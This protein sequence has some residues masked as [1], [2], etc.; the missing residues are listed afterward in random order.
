MGPTTAPAHF[1]K[2]MVTKVFWR[3]IHRILEVYLDDLIVWGNSEE[4]FMERLE[5]T[6]KRLIAH[7]LTLNPDKCVLVSLP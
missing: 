3:E 6:F 1:Q 2:Q 7:R 4:E 5:T